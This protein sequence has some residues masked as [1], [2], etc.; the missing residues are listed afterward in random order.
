MSEIQWKL[1]CL[2]V[3]TLCVHAA[4]TQAARESNSSSSSGPARDH[5]AQEQ[6]LAVQIVATEA[7][8]AAPGDNQQPNYYQRIQRSATSWTQQAEAASGSLPAAA[9]Q[10][11]KQQQ[12]QQ[13]QP[14]LI[15]RR[16]IINLGE[17]AA[18]R[19][20]QSGAPTESRRPDKGGH[21]E[22]HKGTAQLQQASTGAHHSET[23]APE[24]TRLDKAESGPTEGEQRRSGSVQAA[25]RQRGDGKSMRRALMSAIKQ[26][27]G[28]PTM[29]ISEAEM[30]ERLDGSQPT[31]LGP[32]R[33]PIR[34]M[35]NTEMVERMHGKQTADSNSNNELHPE[36]PTQVQLQAGR[37][38]QEAAERED[39][40]GG[41]EQ[42]DFGAHFHQ[43][44]PAAGA[45]TVRRS[46]RELQQSDRG[47][48]QLGSHL[49]SDRA[50]TGAPASHERQSD[51]NIAG[52][53]QQRHAARAE[54]LFGLASKRQ[55]A[56]ALFYGEFGQVTARRASSS[57]N[58]EKVVA[59]AAAKQEGAAGAKH[60]QLR[61]TETPP[62]SSNT[63][64][65]PPT[66]AQQA[67]KLATGAPPALGTG[68]VQNA[69]SIKTKESEPRRVKSRPA[70]RQPAGQP[71]RAPHSSDP[72]QEQAMGERVA[73]LL[74]RLKLYT[75]KEQL[76]KA[77]QDLQRQQPA[78]EGGGDGSS[79]GAPLTSSLG[80]SL[81]GVPD[82]DG[83][84]RSYEFAPSDRALR[85]ARHSSEHQQ[86]PLDQASFLDDE[87]AAAAD[88]QPAD[89]I[90]SQR[91]ILARRNSVP[92]PL[93]YDLSDDDGE[94]DADEG[95][96]ESAGQ[97]QPAGRL[98]DG[99]ADDEKAD[100]LDGSQPETGKLDEATGESGAEPA[101]ESTYA[102]GA[103]IGFA[104]TRPP[105]PDDRS[106]RAD[107]QPPDGAS[108][109]ASAASDDTNE[110]GQYDEDERDP[111]VSSQSAHESARTKR[112][113][114]ADSVRSRPA[115]EDANEPDE[116]G[117]PVET[118]PA[119]TGRADEGH[120][121]A[122]TGDDPVAK[123]DEEM[124]ALEQ[125]IDELIAKGA[126][127]KRA[128]QGARAA[129]DPMRAA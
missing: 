1:M 110:T 82:V 111:L 101:P 6:R 79:F 114:R 39:R 68:S 50:P 10:Q 104:H 129:G 85:L 98:A 13:A 59:A 128:G 45:P 23:V 87:N 47:P 40:R 127:G 27:G 88:E 21:S 113:D 48:A 95:R 100:G 93:G 7:E 99:A 83:E 67:A 86:P 89:A 49:L 71:E 61:K 43:Q 121:E 122:A 69:S 33:S 92:S 22:Q 118:A 41:M 96:A 55:T 90:Q 38:A 64:P 25:G 112:P 106:D 28:I 119:E 52:R 103:G 37:E 14:R 17:L 44:P 76:L 5:Q 123:A 8:P 63:S 70:E 74:D 34:L 16:I 26:Q 81:E 51:A 53:Q 42:A 60:E 107:D 54:Q 72:I 102:D 35:L 109:T 11:Q 108:S 73:R 120:Q 57:E 94:S 117:R 31:K 116:S 115:E 77:A 105:Q 78:D 19:L 125:I 20:F 3:A 24:R 15:P 32:E 126:T 46:A 30:A 2:T 18:P 97:T 91:E 58:R 124:R 12:Q 36:A 56:P 66:A 80:D 9:S 62:G 65:P 75:T 84:Y 29:V 4:Q